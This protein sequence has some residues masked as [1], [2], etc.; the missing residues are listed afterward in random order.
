MNILYFGPFRKDRGSLALDWLNFS[1]THALVCVGHSFFAYILREDCVSGE[2]YD[3]DSKTQYNVI[4]TVEFWG[5]MN[6]RFHSV[7]PLHC[8]DVAIPC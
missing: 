6:E 8:L 1:H 3:D 4:K 7:R 2:W 5:M